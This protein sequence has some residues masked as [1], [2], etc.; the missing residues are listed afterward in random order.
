MGD[1]DPLWNNVDEETKARINFTGRN[2]D[3]G[4]FFMRYEDFYDFFENL[5][6]CYYNDD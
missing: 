6:I 4:I 5:Q 1:D 2:P 3:D